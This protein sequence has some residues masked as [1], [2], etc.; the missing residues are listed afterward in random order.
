MKNAID[1]RISFVLTIFHKDVIVD[2]DN[3]DSDDDGVV[4]VFNQLS[5]SSSA[6][7]SDCSL[8]ENLKS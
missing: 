5:V 3:D 7:W 4:V 8:L 1:L 2:D 6:S